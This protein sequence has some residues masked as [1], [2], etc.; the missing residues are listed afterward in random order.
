M[1]AERHGERGETQGERKD[2]GRAE[3]HRESGET[4]GERKDAGRTKRHRE[5]KETQD[6]P[7][8]LRRDRYT[9]HIQGAAY[10][11]RPGLAS[12]ISGRT[13]RLPLLDKSPSDIVN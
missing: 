1:L 10:V 3:R 9:G 13:P 4:Q 5:S 7:V 6:Q 2:T 11:T 12:D 8:Q